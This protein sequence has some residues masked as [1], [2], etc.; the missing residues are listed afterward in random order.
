MNGC[1]V[2]L[3]YDQTKVSDD[4]PLSL[5]SYFETSKCRA[6]RCEELILEELQDF[7]ASHHTDVRMTSP[8]EPDKDAMSLNMQVPGDTEP[9]GNVSSLSNDGEAEM[10]ECRWCEK[11]ADVEVTTTEEE[12][13]RSSRCERELGGEQ[14]EM[15]RKEEERKRS[16]INFQEELKKIMDAEKQHQK[17]LELM[18]KRAQEKLEQEFQLQQELIR[19][20]QRQV[21]EERKKMEAEHK[22]IKDEDEKKR[23][24]MEEKMKKE[25]EE[26]EERRKREAEKNKREMQRM[27]EETRKKKEDDS[28]RK[29]EEMR[30][31]EKLRRKEE[32]Q[33]RREEEER[34]RV[35]NEEK[36]ERDEEKNRM[37]EEKEEERSIKDPRCKGEKTRRHGEEEEMIRKE[38][39]EEITEMKGNKT[40]KIENMVEEDKRRKPS[41]DIGLKEWR[42]KEKGDVEDKRS[43]EE[44]RMTTEHEVRMRNEVRDLQK[45]EKREKKRSKEEEQEIVNEEGERK[46]KEEEKRKRE[47]EEEDQRRTSEEEM[48]QREVEIERKRIEEDECKSV[49]EVEEKNKIQKDT[50]KKEK[51]RN[52][53]CEGEETENFMEEDRRR[54]TDDETEVKKCEKKNSDEEN[55]RR[56]AKEAEVWMKKKEEEENGETKEMHLKDESKRRKKEVEKRHSEERKG[57]RNKEEKTAK[58]KER[59]EELRPEKERELNKTNER[60]KE[61]RQEEKE[62]QKTKIQLKEDKESEKDEK[63]RPHEQER[64][65]DTM[66]T[67]DNTTESLTSQVENTTIPS[68]SRPGPSQSQ[69]TSSPSSSETSVCLPEHAEQKRLAWMKECVPWSKLSLQNK[70]KQR[71]RGGAGG[72][73]RANRTSECDSL[74][75]PVCP[76]TVLMSTG[77]ESLQQVTTVTLEDLPGCSLSTLAQCRH[78]QSLTLRRCGLKSL[79]GLNHLP[80]L[81]C[82]DVQENHISFVDCGNMASLRVLQLGH[83]RLTSIHGL[84]GAGNLDVLDLSHNLITRIAGLECARRLQSL[85]LAHNQLISTKGL[86]DVSTLLHLDCSHNHLAVVEGLENNALLHTL[87]LKSNN[88]TE[89]PSLI[90]HVLLR[91]L[92]LDD[93]SVSSL[94]GLAVCW[95]PLMQHLSA[96]QNRITLLPSMS[97]FVSLANLDLRFNCISELHSVCESVAGCHFLRDVQLAG[98]PLQQESSWRSV[99]QRAVAGLRTIDGKETDSLLSAPAVPQVSL[100]SGGFLTFCQAQLKQTGDLQ[101]RHRRELSN[102]SSPLDAVKC[103]CR[104][105]TETLQLAVEQRFAHEYGDTTVSTLGQT[106]VEKTADMDNKRELPVI[107]SNM[108]PVDKSA[109][110]MSFHSSTTNE[111]TTSFHLEMAPESDHHELDSKNTA[112]A[113][114]QQQWRKYREK[115]GNISCPPTAEKGGGG[116]G[117]RG[118]PDAGSSSVDRSVIEQ[119]AAIAIQAFW[120]GFILRRRLASALAVV[121]WPDSG[122]DETFEEVDVDGFVFDE[123]AEEKRWTLTLSE[124]SSSSGRHRVSQQPLS[125]K[126][127]GPSPVH[128]HHTTPSIPHWRP[129]QAWLDGE[130]VDPAEERTS[131]ESSNRLK[132]AAASVLSGLSA[133]SEKMVEEW[134][135]KDSNTA[136]LMLK[137]AQKMRTTQKQHQ[138]IHRD[139]F[140]CQQGPVETRNRPAPHR[141]NHMRVSTAEQQAKQMEKV[142]RERAQ[143]WLH[144]QADRDSESERFLPEISSDILNGGRVQLV[145]DPGYSEHLHHTSG[146]WASSSSAAQ[147]SKERNYPR[148]NSASRPTGKEVPSH[149]RIS[150]RDNPVQLS[151]GWGGGKKRVKGQVHK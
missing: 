102:A 64:E 136:L 143:Q 150:F 15:K 66:K 11:H 34:R 106:A 77:C 85:S 117:D 24:E 55:K 111:K 29:I 86:R 109:T 74:Q 114:I 133:K 69:S 39:N 31:K 8:H 50:R 26:E 10:D 132:S 105:F 145:A 71:R 139:P 35:E 128:V 93:N 100:A 73:R 141:R 19:D 41:E 25:E 108:I 121:T 42:G 89:P 62:E 142:K 58:D 14:E 129:K 9:E 98:N 46:K 113:V 60:D 67:P 110:E 140:V 99:L 116:V 112:A 96:A 49:K 120:R 144:Q 52:R 87:D 17:E 125:L 83:N 68:S 104:H 134:G 21:N 147:L 7:P 63:L 118:E 82:V 148:R 101:Q 95:L 45:Q 149:Q 138:K 2:E 72:R 90:N 54:T 135:F 1:P 27:E 5:L 119:D 122:E 3:S 127:L 75:A 30:L 23:K 97:D 40:G 38:G 56:D 12:V 70:N 22:R 115:C 13:K 18:G 4:I 57:E 151:G 53:K 28:K 146:S 92:H 78:L 36:A 43:E 131:P 6:A 80:N 103:S 32:E 88:I 137:R 59:E 33:R 124:D 37:H 130:Q 20:L 107:Q 84:S 76:H 48:N 79:E 51:E 61:K 126:P 123:A 44:Q 16:Q 65:K 47:K 81:C 94:Q 91:E